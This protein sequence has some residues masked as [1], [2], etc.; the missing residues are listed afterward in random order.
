MRA[1]DVRRFAFAALLLWASAALGADSMFIVSRKDMPD[2]N[3]RD[4]VLLVTRIEGETVGIILNRPTRIAVDGL[5]PDL[6]K[7][8]LAGERLYAGGPVGREFVTFLFKAKSAPEQ[9]TE[10]F[11]GIYLASKPELLQAILEGEVKVDALRVFAGYAGWAR[12][13]LEGEVSRGDWHVLRA[14]A[15]TIFEKNTDKLWRE[16]DARASRTPVRFDPQ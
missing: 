1:H 14:D 5:F 6:K 7:N 3:F 4:T 15:R 10:V 13:Q 12:G 11:D 16:M 9:A 2:P 8:V